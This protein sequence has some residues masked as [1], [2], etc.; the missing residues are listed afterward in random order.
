[1]PDMET[2]ML[3]MT[4]LERRYR[5]KMEVGTAVSTLLHLNE[6]W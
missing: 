6:H 2:I 1:M 5:Q 4:S 3:Q